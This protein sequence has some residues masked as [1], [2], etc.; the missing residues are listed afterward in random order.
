MEEIKYKTGE[1]V[2]AHKKTGKYIGEVIEVKPTQAV[3]KVLAV[4]KHP[5]QG[6]LHNPRKVDV[7]MFHQRKA[8]A[9][10]EKTLVPFS[11]LKPYDGNVPDYNESLRDAL[12][13]Q[14]SK[15]EADSSDWSKRSLQELNVL[16]QDY[17]K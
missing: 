15:L 13:K 10:Y 7:P 2:V 8:L 9:C 3:V 17:F 12:G 1:L 14:I 6:D 5:A 16:K 11:A 4:L